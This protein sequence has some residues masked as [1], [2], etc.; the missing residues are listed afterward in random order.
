MLF[1][2]LMEV[3]GLVMIGHEVIKKLRGKEI[4]KLYASTGVFIVFSGI[5]LQVMSIFLL[6]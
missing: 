5:F 1:G 2:V 4:H 3:A 6:I